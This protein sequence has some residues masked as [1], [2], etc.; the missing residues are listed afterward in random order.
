MHSVMPPATPP[1]P[2]DRHAAPAA[3]TR[4][5]AFM[6]L[7]APL[8]THPASA[9]TPSVPAGAAPL[10]WRRFAEDVQALLQATLATDDPAAR[11]VR[12]A[13]TDGL[14][15]RLWIDPDGGFARIET[16]SD[17][18]L[19]AALRTLLEPRRGPRPPPGI[20]WPMTLE[21]RLEPAAP[22]PAD[23]G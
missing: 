11:R 23:T 1:P 7:S 6:L 13:A 18:S 22:A 2:A 21:L 9:Q 5:A 19:A 15:L 10:P 14:R 17:A 3:W 4:R 8:P 12:D 16:P 20:P